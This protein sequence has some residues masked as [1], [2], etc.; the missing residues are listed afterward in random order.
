MKGTKVS[1]EELRDI[2]EG[3]KLNKVSISVFQ[4]MV[5]LFR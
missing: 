2:Y 5:A 1:A 4:K 3:L